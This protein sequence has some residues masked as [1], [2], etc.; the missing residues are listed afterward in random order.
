MA[1]THETVT[2]AW[3]PVNFPVP[4]ENVAIPRRGA[5]IEPESDRA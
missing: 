2:L 5:G 4:P 3:N 1:P